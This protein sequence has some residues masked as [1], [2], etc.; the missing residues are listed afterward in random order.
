MERK[1]QVGAI[2]LIIF[3]LG[4]IIEVYYILS[5]LQSELTFDQILEKTLITGILTSILI[6]LAILL[7]RQK[8]LYHQIR[9]MPFRG[10]PS[11]TSK[12]VRN[13]LETLYRD[14]GA[15]KIVAMDKLM[16]RKE[17]ER[18]KASLEAQID[19]KRQELKS[20]EKLEKT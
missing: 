5:F 16:D 14:L 10:G 12:Q 15:L 2:L 17:Y 6:V 3:I 4:I 11:R 18:K 8:D 7:I 19:K 13:E 20:L 1:G 9:N